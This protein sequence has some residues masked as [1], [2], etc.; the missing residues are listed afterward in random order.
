MYI[1][2]RGFFSIDECKTLARF[3]GGVGC[4]LAISFIMRGL[5]RAS[6][7]KYVGFMKALTSS[8]SDHNTYLSNIRN[9]DFEFRAW[10]V[11]YAVPPKLK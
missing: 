4:I 8:T 3:F 11:T 2:K 5:G 1:Y 6:N 7:P 9:Y 10:P